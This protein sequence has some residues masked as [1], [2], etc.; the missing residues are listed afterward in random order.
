MF[1][2]VPGYLVDSAKAFATLVNL[3]LIPEVLI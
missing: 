1:F 3:A 2:L